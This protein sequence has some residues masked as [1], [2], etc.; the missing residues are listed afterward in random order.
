MARDHSYYDKKGAEAYKAGKYKKALK[1]FDKAIK[2]LPE[3]APYYVKRAMTLEELLKPTDALADWNTAIDLTQDPEKRAEREAGRDK[4]LRKL[5]QPIKKSEN[6]VSESESPVLKSETSVSE[7]ESSVLKSETS[8]SESELSASESESPVS[9]S[10][11]SVSESE[12]SVLKS[13]SPAKKAEEEQKIH[14]SASKEAKKPPM[15]TFSPAFTPES[16]EE[17]PE[18]PVKKP[19]IPVHMHEISVPAAMSAVPMLTDLVDLNAAI[20]LNTKNAAEKAAALATLGRAMTYLGKYYE[21]LAKLTKK[22]GT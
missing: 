20:S 1:L 14:E 22:L 4:V 9:E 13:E 19:E 3:N 16:S 8:V 21:E 5:G 7:S 15:N 17:K 6:S 18:T 11:S 2:L 12:S 10:E